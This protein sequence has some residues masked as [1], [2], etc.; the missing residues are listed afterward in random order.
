VVTGDDVAVPD[1]EKARQSAHVLLDALS[2]F[3]DLDNPDPDEAIRTALRRLGEIDA[4]T[5][6]YD[7]ETDTRTVD[8]QPVLHAALRLL[9]SS[10]TLRLGD[11]PSLTG[12]DA[13][14]ELRT[15]VDRS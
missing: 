10:M 13:I 11:H 7:D 1:E 15:V 9:A 6:L 4:V 8:L 14:Q 2:A 5:I 3:D 12:L